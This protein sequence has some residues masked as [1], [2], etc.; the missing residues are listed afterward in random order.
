MHWQSHL[1][2][3]SQLFSSLP[4]GPV[5]FVLPKQWHLKDSSPTTTTM[6]DLTEEMACLTWTL[7]SSLASPQATILSP[8]LLHLL[9]GPAMA[10]IGFSCT[11]MAPSSM[12][13][14]V[15][16]GQSTV[17]SMSTLERLALALWW[18]IPRYVYKCWLPSIKSPFSRFSTWMLGTPW[19]WDWPR[20]TL[21]V[22]SLS[23]LNWLA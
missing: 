4:R 18:V 9:L 19:S 21:S 20:A 13:V 11:R 17:P 1:F 8:S 14:V 3:T 15:I 5:P 22:T 7:V 12:K 2:A 16:F 6:T 23:T 10:T